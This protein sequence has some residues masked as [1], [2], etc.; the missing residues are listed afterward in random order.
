MTLHL[1]DSDAVI[2]HLKGI[3]STTALMTSLPAQGHV[4][5]SCDIVVAEVFSGLPPQA[6][7]I[8]APFLASLQFL[9]TT[10]TAAQQSGIWR[11]DF[12][13]RGVTIPTTDT[14]IAAVATEHGA[15]LVTGNVKDY[16]MQGITLLPLPRVRKP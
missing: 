12:A 10:E 7:A 1:L 3:T 11:Y 2:D 14:L 6:R 8:A 4:L 13:R 15:V 16:P 9:P 5:C